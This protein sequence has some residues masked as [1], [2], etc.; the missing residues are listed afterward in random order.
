ML[1]TTH[2]NQTPSLVGDGD[3]GDNFHCCVAQKHKK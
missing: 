1:E 3:G 2:T